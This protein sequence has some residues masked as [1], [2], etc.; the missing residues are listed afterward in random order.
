MQVSGNG[1]STWTTIWNF[2]GSSIAPT[3]WSFSEFDISAVA[4]GSS[5]VQI[6]W[7]MGT[8]DSSVVYCGWNIDDVLVSYTSECSSI[9][10]PTPAPTQ[11]PTATPNECNHDGDVNIDGSI[12]AGDAQMA[13]LIALGSYTPTYEQEC[14]ADCNGD[15]SCT[16]GDAQMIFLSALGT[17]SCTD[18]V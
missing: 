14:S 4:A 15:G 12:T 11:P 6:R 2:E 18:P 13:F 16:A 1:G 8:T 7:V 17:G 5:N 10:T 3:T 9:P